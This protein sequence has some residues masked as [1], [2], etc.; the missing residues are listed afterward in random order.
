VR[1]I[2]NTAAPIPIDICGIQIGEAS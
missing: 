1:A 2:A